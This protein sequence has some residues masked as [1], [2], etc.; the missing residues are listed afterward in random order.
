MIKFAIRILLSALVFTYIFP[1]I[2]GVHFSGAFWPEGIL[3]GVLM[4]A[5]S[6]VFVKLV[7]LFVVGTLGLG[8]L[9]VIPFYLFG[10]WLIPALQLQALA[11][12]FPQHLA[13]DGWGGAIIGGLVL[14]LVNLLTHSGSSSNSNG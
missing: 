10:F 13:F 2:G 7:Q 6:W 4:A 14:M 1:K 11:H 9:I 5:V 3:Y 8:A 12:F